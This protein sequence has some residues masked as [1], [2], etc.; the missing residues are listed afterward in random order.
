VAT[1]KRWPSGFLER[2]IELAQRK[3]SPLALCLIDL[4]GFKLI[5]DTFGHP[6]GDSVLQAVAAELREGGES[7]RLGGDEFALLLPGEDAARVVAIGAQVLARIKELR[8][9]FD[10][11][12]GAS[13]GIAVFPADASDAEALVAAA[14]RAL[15]QAKAEG[16]NCVRAVT[17]L[18]ASE[19]LAV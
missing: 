12:V 17:E 1:S 3:G 10:G 16:K 11:S 7:C 19:L 9:D 15:Y 14:D 2:E 13:I 6:A 5:N 4:D 8:F 18:P